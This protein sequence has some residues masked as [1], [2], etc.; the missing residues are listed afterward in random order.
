MYTDGPTDQPVITLQFEHLFIF[1][2]QK[3]MK[4]Q[5]HLPR[6][7]VI[8]D[9]IHSQQYSAGTAKNWNSEILLIFHCSEIFHS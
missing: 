6:L 5:I 3:T 4:E 2:E 7:H 1:Q 8:G 9:S